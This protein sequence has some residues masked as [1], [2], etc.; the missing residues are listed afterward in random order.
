MMDHWTLRD[1]VT[2]HKLQ[3]WHHWF[4]SSLILRRGSGTMGHFPSRP[5]WPTTSVGG[6]ATCG[7][8]WRRNATCAV[9]KSC[10]S[11]ILKVDF[12][13]IFPLLPSQ[14]IYIYLSKDEDY[15][16]STALLHSLQKTDSIQVKVDFRWRLLLI[17]IIYYYLDAIFCMNIWC[18][19][20]TDES[21]LYFYFFH[22]VTFIM[23]CL[24]W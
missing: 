6:T 3:S 9:S 23:C 22:H 15:E 18:D 13:F 20:R 8:P 10:R 5:S 14:Y 11:A 7:S 19:N 1:P 24:D 12:W 17:F 16:S 2:V 4:S 21:Q